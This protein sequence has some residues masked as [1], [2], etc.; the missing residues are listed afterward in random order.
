VH[1]GFATTINNFQKKN[2]TTINDGHF[3]IWRCINVGLPTPYL[4]TATINNGPKKK[5]TTINDGHFHV[6]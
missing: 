2:P 5:P 3:P 1:I 6:E 4:L